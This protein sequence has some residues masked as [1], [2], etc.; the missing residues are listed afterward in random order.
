MAAQGT[1]IEQAMNVGPVVSEEL[2]SLGIETL[3]QLRNLGWE[4]AVTQWMFAY[5]RR[6]HPVAAYALIGAVQGCNI[7]RVSPDHRQAAKALIKRLKLE[8][9]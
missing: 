8:S 5:P 1:P 4:R 6:L 7:T 3:E 9:R 2:R